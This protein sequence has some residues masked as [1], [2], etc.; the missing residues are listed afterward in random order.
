MRKIQFLQLFLLVTL[1]F[2]VPIQA[3]QWID[4]GVRAENGDVIYWSSGDFYLDGG[5]AAF[6]PDDRIGGSFGWAD[7]TGSVV[8]SELSKFGGD[9]PPSHIEGN[10]RYDI[11]NAKMGSQY[12]LP[13]AR[14]VQSLIDNSIVERKTIKLNSN[15]G[16]DGLPSW[17]QGQWLW[18]NAMLIRGRADNTSISLKIDGRLASVVTSDGEQWEGSYSYVRG[19]LHVWKLVLNV[20]A[21]DNRLRD[22]RGNTFNKVSD[23]AEST[24]VIAWRIKSKINGNTLQIVFPPSVNQG[25]TSNGN[26]VAWNNEPVINYWTGT[27]Y[28]KDNDCA[29]TLQ[30]RDDAIRSFRGWGRVGLPRNTQCRI[31][32]LKVDVGSG[33]RMAEKRQLASEKV[34]KV[35]DE[36]KKEGDQMKAQL[37]QAAGER[38][39][40]ARGLSVF[41]DPHSMDGI[42]DISGHAKDSHSAYQTSRDVVLEYRANEKT[43]RLMKEFWERV[44]NAN[45]QPS[46]FT[47]NLISSVT[48]NVVE[49]KLK[50]VTPVILKGLNDYCIVSKDNTTWTLTL[51]NLTQNNNNGE[52]TPTLYYKIEGTYGLI[53]LQVQELTKKS[54]TGREIIDVSAFPFLNPNLFKG[55]LL[56]SLSF[57]LPYSPTYAIETNGKR[58]K[59]KNIEANRYSLQK[60][61]DK[62]NLFEGPHYAPEWC[63]IFFKWNGRYNI[64]SVPR[65][66]KDIETATPN[67]IDYLLYPVKSMIQ[68]NKNLDREQTIDFILK[69][70]SG[71]MKEYLN[72]LSDKQLSDIKE[73]I[74]NEQI[75]KEVDDGQLITPK[76]MI[77]TL[78]D[79]R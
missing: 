12:R 71:I 4:M 43:V 51:A 39:P 74:F 17:V 25:V 58:K 75:A 27:L 5:K 14:E 9:N 67:M 69:N 64:K 62:L 24:Y 35:L 1:F 48:D 22:D 16:K 36:E 52:V 73:E 18:N 28:S 13:T 31:R 57:S 60:A 37:L 79:I 3:Q 56:Y 26:T 8:S 45:P 2:N 55:D 33:A 11:V 66:T 65:R 19:T 70:R 6:A 59:I 15:P 72:H 61:N 29:E 40:I 20:D 44:E 23:N 42:F 21:T 38:S 34:Q 76:K 68:A 77:E 78:K 63:K 54:T 47:D 46:D 7:V 32:A 49:Y 50:A 53:R 10:A 41:D 30:A